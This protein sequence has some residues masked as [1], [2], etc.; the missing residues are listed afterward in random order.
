MLLMGGK[1]ILIKAVTQ[2]IP[3]Y[4]MSC[5]LLPKGLC[6]DLEGMERN[7]WWGQRDQET[8]M[9]WVSWR[10]MCMSKTH[11]GMGFRN[12]HAFNL[13]MLAK[14]AWRILVNPTSLVAR[15]YKAR[16]FPYSD[17][18]G[19][20][21]G[22]SPSYAWRSIHSSLEVVRKGTRWRVGNG[23]MI[24]IWDDKWLPS[25]TTYKICSPQQNFGD[26]PM[27][28]SLID[29]ETRCWK[30]DRIRS[31]FLP[32][33]AETILNIPLSYNL[34]EDKIIWVGNKRGMFSVKSA[35]YVALPLVEKS[36]L[37][38]CSK[39][40]CR[41]PLWKEMW[42]LKLP[43]KDQNFCLESMHGRTANEIESA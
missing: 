13:A 31:F 43:S 22:G 11:G 10:K 36:E 26:F 38:E 21:L 34:P 32:F 9:S 35:Y 2:A 18:L 14:Q 3:T 30:M 41:T 1:E 27:V 6:E 33:E 28:S 39:E 16:Y 15:I 17:I 42:Q 5:F 40:D 24:H 7:F 29:E 19:S 8:K 25:P 4:T 37:G 20:K 23:R 12:L